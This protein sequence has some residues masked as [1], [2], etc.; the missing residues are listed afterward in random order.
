LREGTILTE[1][2]MLDP[3]SIGKGAHDVAAVV[4]SD[5]LGGGRAG[6]IELRECPLAEQEAV[7]PLGAVEEETSDLAAGIDVIGLRRDAVG[8]VEEL[9][10]E[11]G[12]LR[13]DRQGTENEHPVRNVL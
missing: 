13:L 8:N 7:L 3:G 12:G 11:R 1:Q 2:A 4:E 9:E 6:K 5:G 10:V